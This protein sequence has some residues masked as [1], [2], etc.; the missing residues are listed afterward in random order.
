MK[1]F[2]SW[3]GQRS[4]AVAHALK[5]WLPD[6][7]QEVTAWMSEHDIDAGTRWA[8]KLSDILSESHLG[9]VCLTP[10][11]QKAP[12][13]IYESGALSKSVQQSRLIPYLIGMSPSDLESPLSQFQSVKADAAGTYKLLESINASS[14]SPLSPDR[15]RRLFD[16]LWPDLENRI[17]AAILISEQKVKVPARSDHDILNEILELVRSNSQPPF[18]IEPTGFSLVSLQID[19]RPLLKKGNVFRLNFP[20]NIAAARFLD[21]IWFKLNQYGAVPAYTYCTEWCLKNTRTNQMLDKIG[22]EYCRTRGQENDDT[23]LY[24]LDL[25]DGDTLLTVPFRSETT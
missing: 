6:V 7:L 3:S 21:E 12:W 18:G 14:T 11:N 19:P 2:I 22:R 20:S 8:H 24:E 4:K 13:L 1:V 9:I 16:K 5:E 23:P 17:T 10:E 25:Q 15:V